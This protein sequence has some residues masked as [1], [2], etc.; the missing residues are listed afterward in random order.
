MRFN[1]PFLSQLASLKHW[2]KENAKRARSPN[3]TKSNPPLPQNLAQLRPRPNVRRYSTASSTASFR[4]SNSHLRQELG[5]PRVLQAQRPPMTTNGSG[6][7]KRSS[8]SPSPLTPRSSY[9]RSASGLR[10]RKSTSSSLSSVRSIH[11]VHSHSKASST[12]ST[13]ASVASPTGSTS[14][15]LARSPH[16]SVKVLPATPTSTTFPSNIRLVRGHAPDALSL[17]EG[18]AAFSS[19]PPPSPGLPIFAKRKRSVFKGPMLSL[20]TVSRRDTGSRSN[21]VQ[22]RRSEEAIAEED[23]EDLEVE[24]VEEFSPIKFG[25]QVV[26]ESPENEEPEPLTTAGVSALSAS[27]H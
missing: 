9:R 17:S 1:H 15:K 24:E 22:G 5:T 10:G 11:H 27:K 7:H 18:G 20:S 2:F 6:I 13:T 8:L 25:E 26:L 23:E 4:Y 19:L 3:A 12:S 21:S 14:V 16:S